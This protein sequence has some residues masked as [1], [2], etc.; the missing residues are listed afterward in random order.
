MTDTSTTIAARA[1]A[2]AKEQSRNGP[3]FAKT[4][5]CAYEL[6]RLVDAPSSGDADHDGDADAVDVFL[7]AA[8]GAR[9]RVSLDAL[10]GGLVLP[11]G[12]GFLFAG[13]SHGNG[14]ATLTTGRGRG[15]GSFL[16]APDT[17]RPRRWDRV[18]IEDVLGWMSHSS[19][20]GW[21][22]TIGGVR[23]I[24]DAAVRDWNWEPGGPR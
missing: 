4:G 24:T 22:E 12:V 16:W 3:E 1:I 8:P 10:R 6:R 5:M 7:R 17:K 23:T 21:V 9:H 2:R 11:R 15:L 20:L 19:P 14:H 18:T 13:G